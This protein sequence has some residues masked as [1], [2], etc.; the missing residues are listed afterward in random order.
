VVLG[1]L[2]GHAVDGWI[3]QI[4]ANLICTFSQVFVANLPE[5][6]NTVVP[7]LFLTPRAI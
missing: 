7:A 5:K 6:I 1:L 2:E 3:D 4:T